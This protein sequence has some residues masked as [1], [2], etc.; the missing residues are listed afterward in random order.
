[1]KTILTTVLLFLSTFL[2]TKISFSQKNKQKPIDTALETH[3]EKWKVKLHRPMFGMGKP[4]FGPFTTIDLNKLDSPV[5]RKKTKEGSYTDATYDISEG[6]DWDFSKY[7]SVEKRK[8]YSMLVS[9]EQDTAELLFSIYSISKE[10]NLTFFGEL[11][12]KNDEGKNLTLGYKI[13]ISGIGKTNN[14][15]LPWRF[16]LEDS[17]SR[18][19]EPGPYGATR[20]TRAYII[21]ADDS[22]FTEPLLNQLGSRDGKFFFE[23]Q[24]GI[25]VNSTKDSHIAAAKF[26]T[27]GDLSNP[28]YVWIRNDL[29]PSQQHAIASVF[30]LLI[31]ATAKQ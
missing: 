22:L 10:K 7:E 9:R 19:Q 21:T 4:E 24:T 11:M 14:D 28:F 25:F 16:F 20:L 17:F 27:P 29:P 2:C 18:Q 15:S 13:N 12:S 23:W 8:A 6:W 5:L 1:M 31:S 3:S 30:A 26:G